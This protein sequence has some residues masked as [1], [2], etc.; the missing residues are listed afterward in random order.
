MHYAPGGFSISTAQIQTNLN[1]VRDLVTAETAMLADLQAKV[2]KLSSKELSP[3]LLPAPD[4]VKILKSAE[5]KLPPQ[6]ML[7]RDPRERP[8]YYYT[9][10]ET[11][12]IALENRLVIAIEIPLLDVMQKFHINKNNKPTSPL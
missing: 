2:S 1:T 11:N 5:V 7:P 6:L 12:T 10:L 9:I 4:L 3:N 8:W